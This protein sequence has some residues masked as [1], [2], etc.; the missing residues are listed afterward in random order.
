MKETKQKKK[1]PYNQLEKY[2]R[3][4][5]SHSH[6]QENSDSGNKLVVASNGSLRPI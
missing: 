6:K 4:K 2:G 1:L 3:E 5:R